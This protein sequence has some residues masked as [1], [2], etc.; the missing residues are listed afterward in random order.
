V[1][2]LNHRQKIRVVAY[3][4]FLHALWIPCHK[5]Y[6]PLLEISNAK[7]SKHLKIIQINIVESSWQII[8]RSEISIQRYSKDTVD[9][10]LRI[11]WDDIGD[12]KITM[13]HQF[14]ISEILRCQA[15]PPWTS[16]SPA[17]NKTRLPRR[18][19]RKPRTLQRKRRAEARV[20]LTL[21]TLGGTGPWG[22]P[23][24]GRGDTSSGR[25][26]RVVEPCK[27]EPPKLCLAP[28]MID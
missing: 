8:H 23:A 4:N 28:T 13:D 6:I 26:R 21:G 22:S 15:Q 10:T 18:K 24:V 17:P 25:S 2:V 5:S 27:S 7:S 19:Q 14:L 12:M 11:P 1:W 20:Q 16:S 3:L 9:R